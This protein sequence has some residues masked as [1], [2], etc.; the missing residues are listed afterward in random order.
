[1]PDNFDLSTVFT[2]VTE[3]LQE[4]Q[5]NLDAADEYNGNH[6]THMVETFKL[7]QKAVDSKSDASASDQ[8]AFASQQLRARTTQR[9]R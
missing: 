2:K 3:A 6:G 5:S 8:L 1:M 7:I 4:N 9:F